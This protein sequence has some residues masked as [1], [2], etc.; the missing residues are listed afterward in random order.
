[1]RATTPLTIVLAAILQLS[2]SHAGTIILEPVADTTLYESVDGNASNGAG[3]FC[4]AGRTN[5]GELRRTLVAFDVAA[6]V[7]TGSIITS[8][9]LNRVFTQVAPLEGGYV[10]VWTTTSGAMWTCYGSVLDNQ[11]SDPTTV[12]PG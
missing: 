5:R 3:V 12:T 9:Q 4:F 2:V 11:T 7:P 10:D 1:M 8:V 6:A